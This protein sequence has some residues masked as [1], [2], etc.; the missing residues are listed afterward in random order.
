MGLSCRRRFESGPPVDLPVIDFGPAQVVLL[1]GEVYVA[2]QLLAQQLRLNSFVLVMG[3]GECAAGYVSPDRA[4][5][6]NDG[7][8]SDWC[9]VAPHTP[10]KA[11]TSALRAALVPTP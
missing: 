6:E 9:W 10:E 1:P 5:D 11:L 2:F 7:N 8:L 4:W 3:Y